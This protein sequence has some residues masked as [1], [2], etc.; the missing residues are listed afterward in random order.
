MGK[1]K[2][3]KPTLSNPTSTSPKPSNPEPLNSQIPIQEKSMSSIN[4]TNIQKIS[5]RFNEIFK[6]IFKWSRLEQIIIIAIIAPII[7]AAAHTYLSEFNEMQ[8]N[9]RAFKIE[10]ENLKVYLNGTLQYPAYTFDNNTR[11]L[12]V[13]QKIDTIYPEYGL[14]YTSKDKIS[15][16][17]S[18]LSEDLYIF[19]FRL[20]KAEEQRKIATSTFAEYKKLEA[21]GELEYATYP[22]QVGSVI[23]SNQ[24][25]LFLTQQC[26]NSLP[27]ILEKLDATINAK[28]F[29]FI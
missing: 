23:E 26:E 25:M 28:P 2:P 9:A 13:N 16:F 5:R 19:Y 20:L 18:E 8:N 15:K 17:D 21:K 29:I 4:S 3:S 14:Y 6:E 24:E 11:T 12:G 22:D 10:L 7:V 27:K 1:Q